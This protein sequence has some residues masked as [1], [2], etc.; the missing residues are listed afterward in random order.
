MDEFAQPRLERV[1]AL[2]RD[3]MRRVE[4]ESGAIYAGWSGKIFR[5]EFKA[6]AGNLADY[7]AFRRHDLTELQ[8]ELALL[9]LSSLGRAEAH[10]GPT[11]RA[12]DATLNR[13]AG[14]PATWPDAAEFAAG[15]F[16]LSAAQKRFF[17]SAHGGRS[18]RIMTT[19]P[20][21]AADDRMLVERLVAAG[22]N[23][24]RINCAHDDAVAW[25]RMIDNVRQVAKTAGRRCP[26]LMDISGPK[27]RVEAVS[28]T[29]KRLHRGDIFRLSFGPLDR[30]SDETAFSI[31]FPDVAGKLAVDAPVLI[32]DG[33]IGARVVAVE[34]NGVVLHVTTAREKGE[35]LKVEKGVNMPTV[36]LDIDPLTPKDFV[37]LDFVAENADIVGYSFVQ[38]PAD[39][40]LLVGELAKR[41]PSAPPQ[42]LLLKIETPLAV[43]NL[44]RLLVAAGGRHP[45]GVMIARGDL[46]MEVGPERLSE[47]QEEILWLCEAA[48]APVVWAT[49][50]L[51]SMVKEGAPSRAEIT[52]AAMGQRAE[53]VMLNK[54]PF[55]AEAVAFLSGILHRM[56]R[57]Q[58]KKTARLSA[59]TSWKG[60]QEL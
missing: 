29:A 59:L 4:E 38:R 13:L 54:G 27:V 30:K 40:D 58:T 56:D 42:P 6:S 39:V 48:H 10:I 26:V 43:K 36:E 12:V 46:A 45:V 3:A 5:G 19:L 28:S 37:D 41:R 52:D 25:E 50:V 55:L 60:G 18:T 1:R 2:L 14:A 20:S 33:K 17:G 35:K 24:V 49:Q 21:E 47:V 57:H 31:N 7:L 8:D 9:G 53:C 32:N 23:C 11:L 16:R 34:E 22:S 51:E 44:P 15:G